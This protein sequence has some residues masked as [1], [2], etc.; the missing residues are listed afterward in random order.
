MPFP[1]FYLTSFLSDKDVGKIQLLISMVVSLSVQLHISVIML[2]FPP[3]F[4]FVFVQ[5]VQPSVAKA[6]FVFFGYIFQIYSIISFKHIIGISHETPIKYLD[7]KMQLE[8]S[9]L[10]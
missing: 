3:F 9:I 4:H 6:L 1:S 10:I 5:S 7:I 2:S 8:I